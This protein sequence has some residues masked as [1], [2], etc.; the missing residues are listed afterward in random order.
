MTKKR[1]K[2]KSP[3]E[4]FTLKQFLEMFPNDDVCLDYIRNKKYP[5]RIDCPK[6]EK[7]ALFHRVKG[8][9][10]YAC[11]FCG[12]QIS[13]T[14]NTIFHK[15]R[16]PLTNWFYIIYLM[17]QTR[18]GISAKQIQRETGVTYKTAWR[19]CK[20]VRQCLDENY[21]PFTGE[22]EVDESFFGS[23]RKG[24]RGRGEEGK[25][26]I[27]GIVERNGKLEARTIPNAK[28]K[29]ILPIVNENVAIEAM[30]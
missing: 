30:V 12:Y 27:L 4:K 9:K 20:Q 24:K 13:P 18:G 3:M 25:I 11:D 28:S 21:S 16:T 23:R 10:S 14:S 6:C 7:N 2:I 15:S 22:V 17:A 29:T 8:R 1:K 19:M 26:A 5:K